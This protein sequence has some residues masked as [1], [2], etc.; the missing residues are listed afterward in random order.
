MFAFVKKLMP[1]KDSAAVSVIHILHGIGIST[2]QNDAI[3]PIP[4]TLNIIFLALF[5]GVITPSLFVK[6]NR[7]L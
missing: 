3:I 2:I 1:K 5:F 4:Q 6:R 7:E